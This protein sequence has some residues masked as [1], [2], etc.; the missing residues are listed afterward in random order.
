LHPQGPEITAFCTLNKSSLPL[1]KE[2]LSTSYDRV[3]LTANVESQIALA[4]SHDTFRVILMDMEQQ[5]P[6]R[7]TLRLGQFAVQDATNNN[8]ILNYVDI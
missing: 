3:S 7:L 5:K 8:K 4:S 2:V 6:L 1:F